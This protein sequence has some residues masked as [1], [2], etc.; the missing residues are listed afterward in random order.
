MSAASVVGTDYVITN[1]LDTANYIT[2]VQAQEMNTAGWDIANHT[3][4]HTTLEGLPEAQIISHVQTAETALNALGLTRASKHVA[5]P[6]GGYGD[7]SSAALATAGML[8]GR[9]I[10]SQDICPRGMNDYTIPCHM[11]VNTNTLADVQGYVNAAV[12]AG[13]ITIILFHGL[14]AAGP[15]TY[16][17]L[18][19][20]FQAFIDWIV[21]Q[22][23]P[24]YTITD[25]YGMR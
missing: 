13:K 4:D 17:W 15:T 19:S 21:A 22:S 9:T 5:Y 2:S 11:V 6:N 10:V 25:L 12:T 24:T 7:A 14:V 20:D 3:D 23:I 18:I 8:T 16:E 1:L